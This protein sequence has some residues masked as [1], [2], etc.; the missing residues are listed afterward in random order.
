MPEDL[1]KY[2]SQTRLRLILWFLG[3]L[4]FIGLGLVWI[5]YGREA[6]LLGFLCLLGA[7][8]PIGLIAIFLLLLDRWDNQ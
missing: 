5:L 7:S 2:A 8:I 3:I 1:R 4:F 6:A